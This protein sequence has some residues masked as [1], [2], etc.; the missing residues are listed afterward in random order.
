[1]FG[2]FTFDKL[3]RTGLANEIDIPVVASAQTIRDT[4]EDVMETRNNLIKA[5][6]EV[7]LALN[8]SVQ[9]FKKESYERIFQHERQLVLFRNALSS[10][11]KEIADKQDERIAELEQIS[12]ELKNRILSYVLESKGKWISFKNEYKHDLYCF[13]RLLMDFAKAD[14]S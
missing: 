4:Y 12:D 8:E 5:R 7:A 9:S 14:N 2:K 1:M 10:V 13:E 11:R 3:V 6:E